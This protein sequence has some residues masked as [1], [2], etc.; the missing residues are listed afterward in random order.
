MNHNCLR[1]GAVALGMSRAQVKES[2]GSADFEISGPANCANSV[3]VLNRDIL[4]A[5]TL[6]SVTPDQLH[7]STLRVVYRGDRVAAIEADGVAAQDFGFGPVHVGDSAAAVDQAF[8]RPHVSSG[9]VWSYQSVLLLLD[10]VG[11]KV[12]AIA[13]AEPD[14]FACLLPVTFQVSCDSETGRISSVRMVPP[15]SDEIRLHDR[16]DWPGSIMRLT[17]VCSG[18]RSVPR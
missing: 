5:T 3:Y 9:Q 8:G 14:A 16:E 17:R 6:H 1:L 2:L 4:D 10:D 15:P 18:R 11:Q 12:E 13:V 7:A